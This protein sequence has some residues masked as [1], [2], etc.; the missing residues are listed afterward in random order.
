MVGVVAIFAVSVLG[1]APLALA[2][3][4]G[5]V[6]TVNPCGF[7]MLP[8]YLSYFVGLEEQNTDTRTER[9]LSRALAVA[10]VLTSGFVVVFGLMGLVI[11]QVSHRVQD[12]LP[13]VTIV[14]GVALLGLGGAALRG[15]SLTVRL[16]HLQKGTSSRELTSVFLFGVSYALSSLTCTIGPFLATTS[17]TFTEDGAVAGLVTFVVYGVGMGATVGLLTVAVALARAGM[18]NHFRRVLRHVHTLSG[19]LMITTGAYLTY[20]GIYEVRLRRGII[21][22]DPIIDRALTIQQW[23]SNWL[24][25]A[26]STVGVVAGL[27]VVATLAIVVL[28]RFRQRAGLARRGPG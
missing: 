24:Y 14:I 25:Q 15:H 9:T 20:Y 2:F 21:A 11:V 10:A 26:R 3:A 1:N 4:A 23:L 18:V 6:A 28:R 22:N 27:M 5:M 13:W 8:A 17:S 12:G 19:L 7:A 16:P